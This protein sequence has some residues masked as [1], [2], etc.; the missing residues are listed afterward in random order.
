[1]KRLVINPGQSISLQ[2]HK[3]REEHWIVVSGSGR[4]VR[5]D[6]MFCVKKGDYIYIPKGSIHRIVADKDVVVLIEIQMGAELSEDDIERLDD[7][8]NRN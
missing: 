1:M 5:N 6:E 7:I 2:R 3:N 4:I 8:Y